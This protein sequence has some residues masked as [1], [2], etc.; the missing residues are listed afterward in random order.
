[1][2]IM[3]KNENGSIALVELMIVLVIIGILAAIIIPVYDQVLKHAD[4]VKSSQ[5][6]TPTP[7]SGNSW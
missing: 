7:P 1:M 5:S 4:E 6:P 3:R 2:V